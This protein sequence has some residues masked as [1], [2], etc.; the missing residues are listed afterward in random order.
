VLLLLAV[1]VPTLANFAKSS[2]YLPQSNP[3]HYLNIATKMH[4]RHCS[5]L[6]KNAGR[7]CDLPGDSLG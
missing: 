6:A 3:D 1:A 5:T 2:W 7:R 4:V